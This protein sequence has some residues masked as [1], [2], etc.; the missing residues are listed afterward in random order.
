MAYA[1][2]AVTR[3]WRCSW[4]LLRDPARIMVTVIPV[5]GDRVSVR[6]VW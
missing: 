3:C 1:G 6:Q 4:Q 5:A 2:R